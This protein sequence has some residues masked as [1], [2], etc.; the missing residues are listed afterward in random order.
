MSS[1]MSKRFVCPL[2]QD[3][4]EAVGRKIQ[5]PLSEYLQE[6]DAKSNEKNFYNIGFYDGTPPTRTLGK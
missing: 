1:F 6:I 4:N 3:E 5:C 2:C